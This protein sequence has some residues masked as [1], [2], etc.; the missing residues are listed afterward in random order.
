MYFPIDKPGLL[1]YYECME[2]GE[3]LYNP[4]DYILSSQEFDAVYEWAQAE[5]DRL[6]GDVKNAILKLVNGEQKRQV[7]GVGWTPSDMARKGGQTKTEAKRLASIE[8]GKKGGRPR[9]NPEE[10]K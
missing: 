10:K 2:A 8:N 7:F 1:G 9:K 5:K 3:M 4:N 6:P